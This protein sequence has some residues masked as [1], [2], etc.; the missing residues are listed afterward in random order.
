MRKNRVENSYTQICDLT[1]KPVAEQEEVL[2]EEFPPLTASPSTSILGLKRRLVYEI[3]YTPL[4]AIS[5]IDSLSI[6]CDHE[7]VDMPKSQGRSGVQKPASIPSPRCRALALVLRVACNRISP[8]NGQ[9]SWRTLRKEIPESLANEFGPAIEEFESNPQPAFELCSKPL[10]EQISTSDGLA[11]LL[12]ED[13]QAATIKHNGTVLTPYW[14]ANRVTRKAHQHWRRLHRSGAEPRKVADI[15]CGAG[16][17]LEAFQNVFPITPHIIGWDKDPLCVAYS[18]LLSWA[19]GTSWEI[20]CHDSLMDASPELPLLKQQTDD[21]IHCCDMLIGNPPY[22]RSQLLPAP[23]VSRIRSIYPSTNKGNFDL[24]VAFLDHAISSLSEGGIAAYIVTNK[25]M[26]TKYGQRICRRLSEDAR[27]LEIEDFQDSQVFAGYTTYTSVV[28]FAKKLP[29]KRFLV[30]HFPEGVTQDSD[31]GIGRTATLPQERLREHPWD[32]AADDVHAILRLIKDRRHPLLTEVIGDVVQGLRTGANQVFVINERNSSGIEKD[33]LLPFVTGE[34]I[35]RCAVATDKLALIFPY[36][37]NEF[38][39][40]CLM[41]EKMLASKY[42]LCWQHLL[43]HRAVLA[44]RSLETNTPWYAYSRSQNLNLAK[45]RKLLVREM[46]PRAEFAA[47]TSGCIAFASGYALRADRLSED[48]LGMWAALLCTPTMEFVLRNHG[49]QLQ[50]GWFRL[51]K[52]HLRRVRAPSLSESAVQR[53]QVLSN[54]YASDPDNPKLLDQMDREVAS[55]FG[56]T[57]EHRTLIRKLLSSFHKRSLGRKYKDNVALDEIDETAS[58]SIYEPVKLPEYESAHRDRPDLRSA[59]TFVPNKIS[60]IHRWFRYSQGFSGE[61]VSTLI[62]DMGV[63]KDGLVLDPFTGCGTTN[64]VCRAMGIPSVGFEI[65]P[66]MVWVAKCKTRPWNSRRLEHAFQQLRLPPPN[67][68]SNTTFE[69]SIFAD[70]LRKAFSVGILKQLW[71]FENE[72]NEGPFA[73]ME[74]DF[75]RLALLGIME[76]V[77]QI[78]KHGSHYRFMLRSESIGLQKLNTQIISPNTDIRPILVERI[79][80]M[81]SDVD[82]CPLA[83]PLARCSIYRA[84]CR[85]R[86]LPP[87]SVSA[88]ITSPP[89][90][91]R[92]N[93]IAQ[94]KA[95]FAL[96]S[97]VSDKR[98]FRSLVRSTFRSHVEAQFPLGGA[99]SEWPEVSLILK[100]MKLSENNNPKIPHMIAGYFDDLSRVL[101]QLHQALKPGG[102]AAFVLGNSRWG[103]VVV[104]VDHLMAMLA[105]KAGFKVDKIMVTRLKGNSPQ[106]MRKYGRIPVRESVVV[107]RKQ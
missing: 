101:L 13:M 69:E 28:T 11:A 22:V 67:L 47:D 96:L 51:L 82:A 12:L 16:T 98:A 7:K 80:Q 72:F 86:K 29:A 19:Q 68:C 3:T 95:E 84:D 92:N 100:A 66:L 21:Q 15:S 20:E 56:L 33:V 36:R 102:W 61:L 18:R 37:I 45:T 77:S 97:L 57:S 38:G 43:N 32:F 106:Q 70:Y 30:T 5:D 87:E 48:E 60:P 53:L 64:L 91:N 49:T 54:Q 52:H 62:D 90:L 85:S 75:L 1:L 35:R 8:G 107:I 83:R 58:P 17:F 25:F 55:A 94:Q 14:L 105:E 93:Y 42:P 4:T 104:P 65:S 27:V 79:S 78:R 23:Y 46:M 71:T 88:V 26:S 9:A 76:D 89:Y 10:G 41:P 39:E 103:G 50:S 59:V 73:K 31:P 40:T 81:I 63:P 99:T 24:S 2:F 34:H 74:K 44:E 6:S